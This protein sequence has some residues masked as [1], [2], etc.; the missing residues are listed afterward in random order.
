MGHHNILKP[1]DK[2]PKPKD[3]VQFPVTLNKGKQQKMWE[4][5]MFAIF[6]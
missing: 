1:S 6:A 3:S 4:Q 2:S 5:R